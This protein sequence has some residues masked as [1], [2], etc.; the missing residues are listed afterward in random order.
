MKH[1]NALTDAINHALDR[2]KFAGAAL[3]AWGL[4]NIAD[5]LGEVATAI[6]E[7]TKAITATKATTAR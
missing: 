2:R 6:R 5:G 7:H 4:S 1:D 3:I